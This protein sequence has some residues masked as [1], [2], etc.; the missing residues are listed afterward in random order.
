VFHNSADIW[1]CKL[2]TLARPAA[3]T[4][5]AGC[6]F[7]FCFLFIYLFIIILMILVRPIISKSTGPIIAKFAQLAELLM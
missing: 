6:V 1:K 4:G 7:C 2:I 3:E 5:T